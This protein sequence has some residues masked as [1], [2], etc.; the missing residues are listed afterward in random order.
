[1]LKKGSRCQIL[2]RPDVR[3]VLVEDLHRPEAAKAPGE[4]TIVGYRINA[5]A[6]NRPP[7]SLLCG[8]HRLAKFLGQ[9]RFNSIVRD[10]PRRMHRTGGQCPRALHTEIPKGNL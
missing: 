10:V 7:R 5:R 3:F 2:A 8:Q 1:M 4:T 9:G 6:F